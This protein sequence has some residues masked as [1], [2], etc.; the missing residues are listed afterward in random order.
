MISITFVPEHMLMLQDAAALPAHT[1][2]VLHFDVAVLGAKGA[3]GD[4]GD[5][6]DGQPLSADSGNLLT[7]GSDGGT[8]FFLQESDLVTLTEAVRDVEQA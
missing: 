1:K 7:I 8:A 3:K 4:K 5:P 2:T 6:G